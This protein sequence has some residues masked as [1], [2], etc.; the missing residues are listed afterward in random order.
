[1]PADPQQEIGK[2]GG[3]IIIGAIALTIALA[4][5]IIPDGGKNDR[6]NE[7]PP[8]APFPTADDCQQLTGLRN[9]GLGH[10]EA[11]RLQQAEEAFAEIARSF[12][13][14]PSAIRN[15]AICGVLKIENPTQG[16]PAP[17]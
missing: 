16:E 17:D 4:W 6:P 14:D 11:L 2:T 9:V 8:K 3:W 12:P 10:L 5:F 15:L 13:Q 7:M 1:M